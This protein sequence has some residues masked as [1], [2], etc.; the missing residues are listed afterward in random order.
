MNN[1]RQRALDFARYKAA[2]EQRDI[3][4]FE[5]SDVYL[6]IQPL[7]LLETDEEPIRVFEA[8]SIS[9]EEVEGVFREIE[10]FSA[11]SEGD[12]VV[13]DGEPEQI[14]RVTTLIFET[15]GGSKFL[16][17]DGTGYGKEDKVVT[18]RINRSFG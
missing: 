1:T 3:A 9:R 12:H 14:V 13:V 15:E 18:E 16:R 5:R 6:E 7:E 4:V 2:R 10:D 17:S 8:D 11:L